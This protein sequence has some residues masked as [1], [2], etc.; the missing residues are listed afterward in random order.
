MHS[1]NEVLSLKAGELGPFGLYK[2]SVG[3]SKGFPDPLSQGNFGDEIGEIIIGDGIV[4]DHQRP[5]LQEGSGNWDYAAL[6]HIVRPTLEGE[7]QEGDTLPP[8]IPELFLEET[9]SPEVLGLILSKDGLQEWSLVAYG[10][11]GNSR[12]G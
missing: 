6:S 5:L 1:L 8:K 2:A 9:D 7:A 11:A 10:F 3:V 12:G 4:P